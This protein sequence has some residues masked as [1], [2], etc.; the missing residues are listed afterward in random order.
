MQGVL[1]IGVHA[2]HAVSDPG[3]L[4]RYETLTWSKGRPVT[5]TFSKLQELF[6]YKVIINK[7]YPQVTSRTTVMIIYNTNC[8]VTVLVHLVP[9][10]NVCKVLFLC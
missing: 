5:A 2:D 4:R 9:C 3:K 1:G 6:V 8:S 10:K 7:A